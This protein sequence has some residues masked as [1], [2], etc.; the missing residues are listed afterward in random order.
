MTVSTETTFV[1]QGTDG[2]EREVNTGNCGTYTDWEGGTRDEALRIAA[3]LG[4][5][6]REEAPDAP[7]EWT[8]NSGINGAPM[9]HRNKNLLKLAVVVGGRTAARVYATQHN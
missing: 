1:A 6:V 8:T 9:V 5:E 2:V 7:R 4:G 3:G